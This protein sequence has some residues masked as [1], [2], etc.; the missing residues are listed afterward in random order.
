MSETKLITLTAIASLVLSGTLIALGILDAFFGAALGYVIGGIFFPWA[1]IRI[2]QVW[3]KLSPAERMEDRSFNEVRRFFIVSAIF[4]STAIIP[5]FLLVLAGADIKLITIVNWLSHVLLTLQIILGARMVVA[6]Y[7]YRWVS[8]VTVGLTML[9]VASLLANVMYPD[10]FVFV[11]GSVYPLLQPSQLFSFFQ[12]A[13]ILFG[14]TIP[15]INLLVQ[16]ARVPAESRVKWT[17]R[18][19]GG[20][21]LLG[22]LTAIVIDYGTGLFAAVAI[23]ILVTLYPFTVSLAGIRMAQERR[24]RTMR[25]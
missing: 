12:Q 20:G 16:A 21:F 3:K 6:L 22:V 25:S 9:G 14:I 13:L 10:S 24:E 23:I 2:Q 8:S 5:H 19:M 11:E 1:A 15:S 4:T 17:A 18:L 7:N